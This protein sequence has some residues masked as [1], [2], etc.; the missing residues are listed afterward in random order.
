LQELRQTAQNN[1]LQNGLIA[2]YSFD[3]GDARDDSGNGNDGLQDIA[4][5][6]IE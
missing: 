5:Q 2:R 3:Q 1:T 6:S 4:V